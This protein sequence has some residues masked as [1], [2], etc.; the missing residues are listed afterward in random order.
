M[1]QVT[2]GTV[3]RYWVSDGLLHAKGDRLYV[4]CG[5]G[6]RQ[7]LMRETHDTTW[8]GHLGTTKMKALLV[9][10]YYCPKMNDDVKAYV[11]TCMVSQ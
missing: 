7:L 8:A 1:Q 2:E 5:A 9:R 4:P 11:R 3:R 10:S 6:L